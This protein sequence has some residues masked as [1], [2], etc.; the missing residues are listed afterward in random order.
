M[1]SS[2]SH[3]FE[4]SD[5]SFAAEPEP[6]VQGNGAVL[7]IDG[8]TRTVAGVSEQIGD[9]LGIGAEDNLGRSIN[10]LPA[11]IAQA[12]N[13]NPQSGN[14]EYLLLQ[15]GMAFDL[16]GHWRRRKLIVDLLPKAQH[17][18]ATHPKGLGSYSEAIRAIC[19]APTIRAAMQVLS[20]A[21]ARITGFE[22]TM[23][24]AYATGGHGEVL[25]EALTTPSLPSF[26]GKFFRNAGPA[27]LSH[28]GDLVPHRAI[29][30]LADSAS[31]KMVLADGAPLDLSRSFLRAPSKTHCTWLRS[32]GVTSTFATILFQ[33]GRPWGQIV[34][35][36]PE[37]MS[38]GYDTWSVVSDLGR[39]LMARIEQ[40][41]DAADHDRFRKVCSVEAGLASE[42]NRH[43]RAEDA[44][45]IM[46]P[47]LTDFVRADGMAFV[48]GKRIF[49]YGR[50]PPD[51][52]IDKL[53]LWAL[54][55][56]ASQTAFETISLQALLPE[57]LP[58]FES[59][60]GILVRRI[61]TQQSCRLIWFR[62]PEPIP[63]D[64]LGVLPVRESGSHDKAGAEK[65][66]SRPWEVIGSPERQSDF[67]AILNALTTQLILIEENQDL[68]AITGEL[69]Q[70]QHEALREFFASAV[71]D[72]KAPL[73]AIKFALDM[74]K[75]EHFDPQAVSDA[76]QIAETSGE[77]MVALTDSILTLADVQSAPLELAPINT[78]ALLEDVRSVLSADVSASKARLEV[79]DL[80]SVMGDRDQIA[81]LFE[82]V[83]SNAIKYRA[84]D[85][86]PLIRIAANVLGDKV[87]FSVTDNGVGIAQDDAKA[88]FQPM[89]RLHS[90]DKIEGVGLGLTISQGI[91]EA[92]G[93]EIWC[94]PGR[95]EGLRIVFDLPAYTP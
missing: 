54:T 11:A 79:G 67:E 70:Q 30:S 76:D 48:Y 64:W 4:Y 6:R 18:T 94:E 58:H 20:D 44:I 82:N 28:P 85:R 13:V 91:V 49:T 21:V 37:P 39:V 36:G 46:L 87:R 93:G 50:T 77:R 15:D 72:L 34:C 19:E 35:L 89:V 7:V 47:T 81:R 59:A 16:V 23:I 62:G 83:I 78:L 43:G 14:Q 3:F 2:L 41:E 57:A 71:H 52:F 51:D 25:A 27:G 75:E 26:V 90:K 29:S 45:Q 17:P 88:I 42:V 10:D 68:K 38:L 92:H 86:P 12:V 32:L 66:T 1:G 60:C 73:R 5:A 56:A 55:Q 74:M 95:P 53:P 80:P 63:N 22:R 40:D 33:R 24:V 84:P 69:F 9:Y 31:Q 65:Q 61:M 8:D